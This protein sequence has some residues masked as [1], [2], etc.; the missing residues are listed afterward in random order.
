MCGRFTLTS[1][2]DD[3][4][5]YFS[6]NV[7][8]N[9]P[10]RYNIAPT[11][12]IAIIRTAE[13][14]VPSPPPL[15]Q[16]V[17]WGLIPS[18]SGR[19]NVDFSG[20][21]LINARSETVLKKVS[22]RDSFRRRRCLV[23]ANGFYE[24]Q[25]RGDQKQPYYCRPKDGGLFAFA[26]IWDT[27]LHSSGAEMDSAAI[28]TTNAGPSM[29][30]LHRREPVVISA[31]NFSDWLGTHESDAQSLLPLLRAQGNR[32]WECAPVSRDVGNVRNDRPDLIQPVGEAEDQGK[33]VDSAGG[34]PA[35]GQLF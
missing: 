18:W 1:T 21:P 7:T 17:R 23:P 22:F 5:R 2:P 35:Q 28:L 13:V 14:F 10:P 31:D 25:A 27:V 6:M 32:F 30:R 20:S 33:Q 9:F 4:G 12:P 34:E 15:Y 11:Q 3:V 24:W 26:A 8:D 19:A 29:S 16:L